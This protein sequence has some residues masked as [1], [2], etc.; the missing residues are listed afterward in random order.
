MYVR[1]ISTIVYQ[2]VY[3]R[4]RAYTQT[5][6]T[7]SSSNSPPAQ[8]WRQT[9]TSATLANRS[10]LI[11]QA[12]LRFWSGSDFESVSRYSGCTY[13]FLATT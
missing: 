11:S 7:P 9:A 10:P 12:K 3:Q 2:S 1:E 5:Y 4:L 8:R 6:S 13:C